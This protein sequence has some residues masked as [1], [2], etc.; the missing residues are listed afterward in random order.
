VIVVNAAG[1]RVDRDDLATAPG[2]AR[3]VGIDLM[4]LTPGIYRVTWRVTG[5]DTHKTQGSYKFLV[6]P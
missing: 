6:A 1:I 5:T 4:K 2:D 3:T